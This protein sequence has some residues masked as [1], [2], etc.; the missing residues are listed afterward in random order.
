MPR[1]R[2]GRGR[3]T[4]TRRAPAR[5][6]VLAHSSTVA[7]VVITS[8]TSRI[9][10]PRTAARSRTA[11]APA[12]LRRRSSSPRPTCGGVARRRCSAIG[13]SRRPCRAANTRA[14]DSGLIETAPAQ[15][16]QVERHRDEQIVVDRQRTMIGQEPAEDRRQCDVAAVLEAV[17][18]VDQRVRPLAAVQRAG[19]GP[20]DSAAAAQTSAAAVVGTAGG[21]TVAAQRTERRTGRCNG[22]ATVGAERDALGA[23]AQAGQRG[24]KTK[25]SA[26]VQHARMRRC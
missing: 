10:R 17:Q 1:R 22:R 5:R 18:R 20:V 23:F 21:E 25:S 13:C 6:R 15:A 8:S 24:G 26:H 3:R 19:T 16:L 2:R 4:S 14:S 7:P 9:A 12:M 11:N